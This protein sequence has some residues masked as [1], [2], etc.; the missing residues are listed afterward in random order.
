MNLNV[1]KSKVIKLIRHFGYNLVPVHGYRKYPVELSLAERA[2]ID[3]VLDNKL[4]MVSF[5][6]V[7]STAMA[8]KWVVDN[9]IPGDFVE[10]GVW[11]GG[12]A[13]VA[14]EIFRLNNSD[15]HVYLFD[16]FEG[17]TSP[18]DQDL[19][20][21]GLPAVSRYLSYQG[22]N[23]NEW[24]YTSLQQVA[25]NFEKKGLLKEN[26]HFVQGDVASTL[27]KTLLLEKISVLRLDTDWYDSTKIELEVL[28]PKLSIGG[29]L[30]IDDYGSWQGCK[31]AVDEYF[32]KIGQR[33][34][35]ESSGTTARVGVKVVMESDS[36]K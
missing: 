13:L 28:Y 29:I 9:L 33:P 3:Y 36:K 22:I 35:L 12:N 16:T 15:K 17:M 19:D 8:C 27:T 11:Q 21:N 25:K 30:V 6:Q 18:T 14:A 4:T 31:T 32:V 2:I 10:C 5:E 24:C 26:I 34:Y 1:V 7:V 23:H 20:F